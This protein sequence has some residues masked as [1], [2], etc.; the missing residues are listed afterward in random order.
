M[1]YFLALVKDGV[2]EGEALFVGLLFHA[3]REDARPGDGQ[4][5]ALKA[6]LAHQRDIL[7]IVVVEI[8]GLMV[9]VEVA[10]QLGEGGPFRDAVDPEHRGRL[11][12]A[13]FEHIG[14]HAGGVLGARRSGRR[15]S[16]G[17][18]R[19]HSSRLHTGWPRSR[20]PRGNLYGMPLVI[21]SFF[22]F[23]ICT[24][25]PGEATEFLGL[26]FGCCARFVSDGEAVDSFG[27]T[28]SGRLGKGL[29]PLHVRDELLVIR[30]V[31]RSKT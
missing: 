9:G 19:L 7:F 30:P 17:R 15:R 27:S 23:F 8:G 1:P 5:E 14:Q 3:G 28:E 12:G 22:C 24:R 31:L 26:F 4:P 11:G 2:V 21:T 6:H 10:V 29:C 25:W 16:T 18:A 20:R 13:V